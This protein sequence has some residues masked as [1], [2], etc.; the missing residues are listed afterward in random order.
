M[1]G[2][3][4]ALQV[5]SNLPA[6][7]GR[8][9]KYLREEL[10]KKDNENVALKNNVTDLTKALTNLKIVTDK[11]NGIENVAPNST[12]GSDNKRKFR[13]KDAPLAAKTAY[14]YYC[15]DRKE[16]SA[17]K[18]M[19]LLW[20]EFKGEERQKYVDLAAQDKIRFENENA[21][22]QKVVSEKKAE[23]DALKMYYDKQKQELAMEFYE[24]HLVAQSTLP[25]KN[26]KKIKDPDAPKG[27]ISSYLF[28]CQGKS[29][30]ALC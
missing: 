23:E 22:Y 27:I 12:A 24:A 14:K 6:T 16:E 19:R 1:S 29:L 21:I 9:V 15:E 8:Q 18:D 10:E 25:E 4:R 7:P 2:N 28:F 11:V 5:L 26:K 17:Q 30:Y 20:K 3:N 13:N